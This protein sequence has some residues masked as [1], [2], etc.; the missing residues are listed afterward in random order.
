MYVTPSTFAILARSFKSADNELVCGANRNTGLQAVFVGWFYVVG[1]LS[2]SA[3]LV[4][5]TIVG[6]GFVLPPLLVLAG[7]FGNLELGIALTL[8]VTDFTFGNLAWYIYSCDLSRFGPKIHD[9]IK[10]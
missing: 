9:K 3:P 1:A 5:A 8:A 6:H 10:P 7:F 2:Q 4:A